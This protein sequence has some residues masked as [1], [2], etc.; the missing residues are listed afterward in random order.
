MTDPQNPRAEVVSFD[1]EPLIL[2]NA[3]DEPIGELNKLDCHQLGGVLHRAFSLFI[4]NPQRELLVHQRA[5]TKLLWKSYWSNSCC[6]HPRVGE[7]IEAAI[8]RRSHEELGFTTAMSF[9]YK[10]EYKAHFDD[11]GTEHE[12]CSVYV[13]E[14]AAE[15][16]CNSAEISDYQWLSP[17]AVDTMLADETIQTTPWFAMEWEQLKSRGLV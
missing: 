8:T 4:F 11:V 12:L 1:T 9:V 2:V 3:A 6:S 5:A 14:Y 17:S 10:F 7:S 13:G 16:N 15:P